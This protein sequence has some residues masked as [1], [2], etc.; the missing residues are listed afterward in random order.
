MNQITS[1]KTWYSEVGSYG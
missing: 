1:R